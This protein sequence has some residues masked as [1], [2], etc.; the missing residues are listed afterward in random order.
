MDVTGT[1]KGRY[2]A[3]GPPGAPSGGDWAAMGVG[4][5]VA[6]AVLGRAED[7][8]CWEVMLAMPAAAD[9]PEMQVRDDNVTAFSF[10]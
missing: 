7:V 10:S 9:A 1:C 2:A 5:R 8:C 3:V 6:R 4:W